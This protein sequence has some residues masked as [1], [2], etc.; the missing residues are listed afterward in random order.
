MSG[1]TEARKQVGARGY[2]SRAAWLAEGERRFGRRRMEWQFVCPHCGTEQSADDFVRAGL[3]PE[4]AKERIAY[5]CIGRVLD[6]AEHGC[7]STLAKPYGMHTLEVDGEPCF[8]F[9]EVRG[10]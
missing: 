10:G 2:M 3:T 6:V 8:E 1:Q 7:S 4:E 9:A 5:S